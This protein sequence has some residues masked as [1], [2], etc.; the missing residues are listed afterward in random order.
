MTEK[1]LLRV[2]GAAALAA[3]L[4]LTGCASGKT[5][6]SGDGGETLV[7]AKIFDLKT[8]DPA[9]MYESTGQIVDKA[10]YETLVEYEGSDV[11]ETVPGLAVMDTSD[12]MRTFTFTLDEGRVFSSGNPV[13]ADDV[14]FSLERVRGIQGTPSF[15]LDGVTVT[16]IDDITVELVTDDAR[17]GLPAIIANPALGIVDSEV[18]KEHGGTTGT[19]DDAESWLN[20]NSAGSGPYILEQLDLTS[21][22]TM[23]LNPKYNGKREPAYSRILLQNT[24]GATQKINVEGGQAHLALDLSGTQA[25]SLDS[26][27]V[28]VTTSP[29]ANSIFVFVNQNPEI[30]P[31]SASPEFAQAVKYAIDYDDLVEF[32]GDGAQQA[33]GVI[34]TVL[35]GAVPESDRPVHDVELAKEALRASE[36]DGAEIK[37]QYPSDISVN[38]VDLSQLAQ[39][40]Q[41]QFEAVGINLVLAPAPFATEI[42]PYR[43]GEE[44]IGLWY[45]GPDYPDPS[46]YL[47]FVPGDYMGLRA[48]WSEGAANS[49]NEAALAAGSALG[50][51]ER[52]LLFQD[53][54]R[55]VNEQGPF[56]P[57]LH[58]GNYLAHAP[59]VTNVNYNPIWTVDLATIGK[60]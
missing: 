38:G 34:P 58:P 28:E 30:S 13:T 3:A 51:S 37:L 53:F 20:A 2:A 35:L 21:Q 42:E 9:R 49:V 43:N 52:E 12:D 4:A 41:S 1:T 27:K 45:S 54:G 50:G 59:S 15:L 11:T 40:I 22:V 47:N 10:L 56:V 19:D 18:V 39:R 16:K 6:P 29:S 5:E 26:S 25:A 23:V 7:V 24:E 46:T 31:T 17:P 55:A 33:T 60:K 44:Q 32:S 57:I 48:G 14:V 36:Y 8:A